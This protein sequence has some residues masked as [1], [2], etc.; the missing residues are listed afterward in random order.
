MDHHQELLL[1]L[2]ALITGAANRLQIDSISSV[3]SNAP[4]PTRITIF[5]PPLIIAA[6]FFS[7]SWGG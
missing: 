7:D 5:F 4:C 2:S 1:F 3:A 6:A